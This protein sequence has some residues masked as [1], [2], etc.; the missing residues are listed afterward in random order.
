MRKP[1]KPIEPL[2]TVAEVS[3]ICRV[4]HRTVRRWIADERLRSTHLGR[5]VRVRTRDLENFI[6][7]G[8]DHVN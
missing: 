4:T 7:E 2:L 1:G 5:N 3:E 8:C 6:R